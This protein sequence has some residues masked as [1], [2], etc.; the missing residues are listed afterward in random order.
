[1]PALNLVVDES[2]PTILDVDTE[3]GIAEGILSEPLIVRVSGSSLE[4]LGPWTFERETLASM[5]I[6]ERTGTD[7][8]EKFVVR[9]DEN[10]L[11]NFIYPFVPRL[12]DPVQGFAL[13]F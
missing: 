9:L 5:L 11:Y 2:Y 10:K 6:I 12:K 13:H 3:A 7:T 8:G 4:S 1:M